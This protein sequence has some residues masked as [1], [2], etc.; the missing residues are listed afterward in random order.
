VELLELSKVLVELERT[1]V[2]SNNSRQLTVSELVPHLI[3]LLTTIDVNTD[4]T[5]DPLNVQLYAD[6]IVNWLLNVYDQ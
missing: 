5:S 3:S 4:E 6:L 1:T 2:T